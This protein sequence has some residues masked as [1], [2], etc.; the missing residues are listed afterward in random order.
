MSHQRRLLICSTVADM[1]RAFLIPFGQHFRS[2]GWRVDAA[3]SGIS[4][5][6]VCASAFDHVYEMNWSRNPLAVSRAR[7][8]V[9][10]IREIVDGNG[11][12]LVH[13]HTPIAAVLTRY[14]LRKHRQRGRPKL[15]YTAHGFHF[16]DGCSRIR[17]G[18]VGAIERIA[19]AW[20]DHLVVINRMDEQAAKSLGIVSPEKVTYMPGIGLDTKCTYNR[21]TVVSEDVVR[22][23]AE[24]GLSSFDKLVLMVA[25]FTANKR[26]RDL[27]DAIDALGSMDVHVAFAGVGPCLANVRRYA[28]EL[29][30][31]R[32]VHFLGFRPDIPVLM[33]AAAVTVLCSGREG[34]PRSIMEAMSLGIPVVATDVRGSRDLLQD[35][36]GLLVPVAEPQALAAAIGR[37][38]TQPEEA[39][40]LTASAG[41]R[42]QQFDIGRILALHEQLYT[43]ALAEPCTAA[44][45]S[46][47]TAGVRIL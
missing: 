4:N 25:E 5:C 34:L 15:I 17:N 29:G 41:E 40:R 37:I 46:A 2:Q 26:H 22:L 12:D 19:G 35:G 42:I 1:I 16:V 28:S 14:A 11:Y 30:L 38:L 32:R 20:T 9:R 23:R 10:H 47:E 36:A 7:G 3:A 6:R 43:R 27:L 8:S 44:W 21:N 45:P 39:A 33:K 31:D 18:V 13:V 24:L